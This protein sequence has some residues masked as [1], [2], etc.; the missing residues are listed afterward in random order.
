[1]R[2]VAPYPRPLSEPP[3][4]LPCPACPRGR[5]WLYLPDPECDG[6][7]LCEEHETIVSDVPGWTPADD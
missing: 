7:W 4:S 6:V 5:L 1:M 3:Y 2:I